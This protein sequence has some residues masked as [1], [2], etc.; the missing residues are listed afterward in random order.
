MS[1]N[2]GDIDRA[3]KETKGAL[4]ENLSKS[5]KAWIR[6]NLAYYYAAKHE[7]EP[8]WHLRNE[9][10][11]FAEYAYK[12]YDKY[13]KDFNNPEWVETYIFVKARFAKD[14]REKDE[15]KEKITNLLKREDLHEIKKYLED[16]LDYLKKS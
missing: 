16:T 7:K 4:N 2:V 10:L 3:I 15:I 8:Q 1:W 13:V 5:N 12:K 14:E 6:N 9:A 11:R